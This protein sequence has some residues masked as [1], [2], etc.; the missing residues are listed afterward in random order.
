MIK[1]GSFVKKFSAA[2]FIIALGIIYGDIG[3]SPLYVF[4]AIIKNTVISK[5]LIYGSISCIFWTLTI[6]T[7]FKYVI[8]ILQADNRGEG[9]IFALYT[10]VRRKV[11]WLYIPAI[12]GASMLLADGIIT[13]PISI[14]NAIE[15]IRN[16]DFFETIIVPG[17]KLTVGIV[18]TIIS[19]LFFFQRFGTKIV[20]YSF[21]PVMFIWFTMILFLGLAN[22]VQDISILKALNPYY[23]YKLLTQYPGG[24]WLLGAVFLCTTGA[25]ALYSDLGH[26]GKKNIQ[27]SWMYVKLA[28]VCNYLGQ[29]VWLLKHQGQILYNQ[30]PF[31]E[32]MPSW[33]LFIGVCIA[34][35]ATIIASQALISGSF[36]L[37]NEAVNLNFWPRITIKFPSNI[38]GQLY[39]PS[40][41]IILWFGCVGIMLWFRKAE[42]M[43]A[44]YGFAI[45]T[46]MIMTTLLMSFYIFVI[47]KWNKILSSIILFIFICVETSFFIANSIKLFEAWVVFLFASILISIMLIWE[48]SKKV[49]KK[50]LIVT[51]MNL[52]IDRLIELSN[53][54]QLPIFANHLVYLTR[55]TNSSNIEKRII[56]SILFQKPKRANFYWFIHIESTDEPF[57]MD[58]TIHQLIPNKII[59]IDFKLGF[60]MQPR[61]N[62]LF[63]KVLQHLYETNQIKSQNKYENLNP[64]DFHTEI[65]YVIMESFFSI[66][67]ELPFFEDLLMDIYFTIKKLSQSDPKAF[68]LDNA[69]IIIEKVP[70]IIAPK[71]FLNIKQIN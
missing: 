24:F 50:Y 1:D 71:E 34:T 59:R 51:K 4:T 8:L 62:I 49:T 13:P 5:E 12:I 70:L 56:D 64:I 58:F 16:I 28:L 43:E 14:S 38:K 45:S 21:G 25:E 52:N 37:I 68:G 22:L 40:L 11:K 48:K 42:N 26:C 31:Y 44:A 9:G 2:G 46:T 47:R 32:I 3:T 36:T 57:Q 6:Q 69:T 19:L 66:E 54:T 61:V 7:T 27:F 67:N 20:G 39:I 15:G 29:G 35:V 23:G 41:N 33:F 30:N 63:K 10:L 53:D 65:T 18:I 60:K 55:S 17:N